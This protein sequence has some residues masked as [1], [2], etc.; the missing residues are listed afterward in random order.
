MKKRTRQ[1]P[2]IRRRE[3]KLEELEA[4]LDRAKAALSAEDHE[5]LKGAV[6][7]L[8]F[9]TRELEAKGASIKRLRSL[10]S[11]RARRRRAR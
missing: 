7:T 1:R 3:L 9:L 4:I 11:A 2:K 6:D 10:L 8:A 5:K